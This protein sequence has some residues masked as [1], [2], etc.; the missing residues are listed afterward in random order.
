MGI[1]S[2]FRFLADIKNIQPT[3]HEELLE[4]KHNKEAKDDF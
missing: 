4:F 3:I 1:K 2:I